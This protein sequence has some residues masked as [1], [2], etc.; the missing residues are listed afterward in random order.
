MWTFF[1]SRPLLLLQAWHSKLTSEITPE[2]LCGKNLTVF[3]LTWQ[4][5]RQVTMQSQNTSPSLS[6]VVLP[7]SYQHRD[8]PWGCVKGR[9]FLWN[10][11]FTWAD[12]ICC[13]ISFALYPLW[14]L[15]IGGNGWKGD[16]HQHMLSPLLPAPVC[17]YFSVFFTRCHR[18]NWSISSPSAP[19]ENQKT[20]L[21]FTSG[22]ST[23]KT[24]LDSLVREI[25][26]LL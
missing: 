10:P 24:S 23:W 9:T 5:V 18:F 16:F 26:F 21:L 14:G 1:P 4:K 13:V 8:D 7:F 3:T 25:S 19:Q 20:W 11:A 17:P 12:Y 2:S 22:C 15:S 6:L